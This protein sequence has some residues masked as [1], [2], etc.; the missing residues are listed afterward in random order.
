MS[1][2]ATAG[3]RRCRWFL[4]TTAVF[5]AVAFLGLTLQPLALAARLPSKAAPVA[6]TERS[7]E[8]KLAK[9]LDT[10]EERLE[11]FERKLD[12]REDA[13]RE[14]QE[15]KTLRQDL[16]AMDE[17]AIKNFE[18]IEKQLKDKDLPK[19]ILDRHEEA[20]RTYRREMQVL[21]DNL[22]DLDKAKD[23][24]ERRVKTQKAKEH[25]KAKQ[26]KKPHTPLDPNNLPFR[27]HDG[28]KTRKPAEKKE[29]FQKFGLF[30]EERIQLASTTLL[31]G[32]LATGVLGAPPSPADLAETIEVRFSQQINELA[33]S[34]GNDPVR[35]YEYVKNNFAFEPYYGSLKGAHETLLQKAGNDF[36]LASLLIALLRTSGVPARYVL[37]TVDIPINRAMNWLGVSKPEVAADIFA[38]G[39]TPST[40]LVSGGTISSLQLEHVWVETFVPYENY[41]GHALSG[42]KQWVPLDPSFKQ[43]K[44]TPGPDLK[45]MMQFDADTLT[46]AITASATIDQ[47]IPSVTSV[48]ENVIQQQIQALQQNLANAVVTSIPNATPQALIDNVDILSESLGF[49]PASLPYKVVVEGARYSQVPDS[50][51]YRV[52]FEIK[53]DFLSGTSALTYESTMAELAGKKVTLAYEPAT[54]ADATTIN[55]YGKLSN[56]PA[57][58]VE[59]KPTLLV[60][61]VVQAQGGGK[62]LGQNQILTTTIVLPDSLGTDRITTGLVV[63]SYYAVGLPL[64]KISED[65]LSRQA[66]RFS[67]LQSIFANP[68]S[69]AVARDDVLGDALHAAAINYFYNL[70]AAEDL[71]SRISGLVLV[72]QPSMAVVFVDVKVTHTF[73]VP[74]TVRPV[75]LSIDADRH[76]VSPISRSGDGNLERSFQVHAGLFVSGFEQVIFER[77]FNVRAISMTRLFDLANAS[78]IPVYGITQTNVSQIL[79]LLQVDPVVRSDIQNFVSSGKVVTI[80]ANNVVSDGWQGTGYW[81]LDPQTLAGAYVI[82]GGI[83]GGSTTSGTASVSG[84]PVSSSWSEV[85]D[86]VDALLSLVNFVLD[87]N[88]DLSGFAS[89]ICFLLA[90]IKPEI[91]TDANKAELILDGFLQDMV[92]MTYTLVYGIDI[93]EKILE[94]ETL[95]GGPEGVLEYVLSQLV[96]AVPKADAQLRE[97]DAYFILHYLYLYVVLFRAGL[98]SAFPDDQW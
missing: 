60:D 37:G 55:A 57:Y 46:A 79:P 78:G 49:L 89:T 13:S 53:G 56:I 87:G 24:D 58:L 52:R 29:D 21:K 39:G 20:V 30:Q 62:G 27:T 73:G 92:V 51:R 5:V 36:D 68:T 19:V 22:D 15:L 71:I 69:T 74:T 17:Q 50:I 11:K 81:V 25:L 26:K 10:I 77:M 85:L 91:P 3:L 40:I 42:S 98:L 66:I 9:H 82:Q 96:V 8:E 2:P 86:E 34:L 70:G 95:S 93:A 35:I 75:G 76:V 72:R 84:C 65:Q 4:K 16:E 67:S 33:A 44:Y 31:P 61:G 47:N 38:T 41:R 59:M 88:K 7:N 97:F 18:A 23:D 64:Q 12:R 48:S 54:S 28:K 90:G 14:K 63:G 1:Q 94:I 83:N 43:V 80:P 32:M 45:S 6:K